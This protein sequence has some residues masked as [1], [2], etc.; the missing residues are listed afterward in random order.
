VYRNIRYTSDRGDPLQVPRTA[1]DFSSC[2]LSLLLEMKSFVEVVEMPRVAISMVSLLPS[3]I[4]HPFPE[5]NG[6][7]FQ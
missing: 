6:G 7:P 4:A 2:G 3:K 1:R 5:T